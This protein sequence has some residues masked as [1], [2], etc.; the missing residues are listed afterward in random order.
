MTPYGKHAEMIVHDEGP[1]NAEAPLR[2]LSE[3][4]L[5][6]HDLFFSRNHAPVPEVRPEDYRLT[7]EGLVGRPSSFSMDDLR[8]FPRSEVE[9]VM[10]CAGNRR[11]GLIEVAPVPGETPWGAGA[12]GNASWAGVPLRDVLFSAGVG[13]GAR[14]AAF[15]GL[16]LVEKEGRSFHYGGSIPIEK[17]LSPEVLL[18]YEMNGE[19]L[20]PEHG[21]PLRIVAPGYYGARSVKWLGSITL[22][23]GP[24]DNYFQA[25]D[26]KLFAPNV[27]AEVSD[28]AEGLMLGE[29]Q[30][31]AVICEPGEGEKVGAGLVAVRGYALAGGGR[32]VERVDVSRDGGRTWVQADLAGRSEDPWAW[33]LW[34]ASFELSPGEHHIVVRAL[35]SAATT[36][37]ATAA[38]VWNF[39][40]YANNSWHG[41]R[42][43]AS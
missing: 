12:I 42:V 32:R 14:H 20:T 28:H 23:E 16:D 40:G 30:T 17:A 25:S 7:V 3:S 34:E 35:D 11:D 6:P 15:A 39:K 22:Q 26:Y 24:S 21:A 8:G 10:E 13:E 29:L 43:V 38:E 36:Q 1:F 31:N 37:P 19:P 9:A 33:T 27:R 41:V 4:S 18:A 5:T 2:R